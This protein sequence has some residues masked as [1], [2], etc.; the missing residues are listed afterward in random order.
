MKICQYGKVS[1]TCLLLFA[2][3]LSMKMGRRINREFLLYLI[4]PGESATI[5]SQDDRNSLA[6][7]PGFLIIYRGLICSIKIFK[8][9]PAN[10]IL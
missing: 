5:F 2:D 3:F 9:G 4:D 10:P 6:G 1:G 8:S 7:Q